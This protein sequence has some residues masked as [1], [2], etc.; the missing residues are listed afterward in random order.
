MVCGFIWVALDLRQLDNG[1][2]DMLD[3]EDHADAKYEGRA[4]QNTM[5]AVSD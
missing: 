2:F 1:I 4:K 3:Q 5:E